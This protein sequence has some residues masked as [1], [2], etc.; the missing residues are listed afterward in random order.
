MATSVLHEPEAP[1][2]HAMSAAVS[3][4]VVALTEARKARR[5]A[6]CPAG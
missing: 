2:Y 6:A 1:A 3:L 5:R 4:T